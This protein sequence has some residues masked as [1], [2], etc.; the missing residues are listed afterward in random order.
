MTKQYVW[1][2]HHSRY[3]LMELNEKI[4]SSQIKVYKEFEK[5]GIYGMCIKSIN[6]YRYRY[7]Y[8]YPSIPNI[9]FQKIVDDLISQCNDIDFVVREL[10]KFGFKKLMSISELTYEM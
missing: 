1:N 10:E 7:V 6:S 3:E 5:V 8:I 4:I 9:E 2:E